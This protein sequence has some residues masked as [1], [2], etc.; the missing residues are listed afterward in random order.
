MALLAAVELVRTGAW[1]GLRYAFFGLGVLVGGSLCALVAAGLGLLL[2]LVGAHD[3]GA[4][5][6][7]L[8]LFVAA[9]TVVLWALTGMRWFP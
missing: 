6:G 7:G 2:T 1:G 9:V 3:M 8:G 4:W 5:A